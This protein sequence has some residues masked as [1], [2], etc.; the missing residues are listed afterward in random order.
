MAIHWQNPTLDIS[1]VWNSRILLRVC[2]CRG[3]FTYRL[4]G[5]SGLPISI[6]EVKTKRGFPAVSFSYKL[7]DWFILK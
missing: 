6:I 1:L 4:C 3:L 2:A 5:P 7:A